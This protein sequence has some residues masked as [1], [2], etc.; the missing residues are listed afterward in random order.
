[1][2]LPEDNDNILTITYGG[3][4]KYIRNKLNQCKNIDSHHEINI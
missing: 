1:M 3:L 2:K 4:G